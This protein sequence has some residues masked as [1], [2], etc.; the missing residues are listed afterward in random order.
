[1]EIAREK[2]LSLLILAAV[3]LSCAIGL[4]PELS[5]TRIDRNDNVSHYTLIRGMVEAIEQGHNPL[6]FWS[7]E[8][9]FGY[10][11]IRV[12]QPLAH[13][14]VAGLYFALGKTLSLMTVFSWVRY[15]SLVLLPLTF[16]AAARLLNFGYLTAAFAGAISPLLSAPPIY[17]LEWNSYI[18]RGFGLF[19]Q[20]VAV[21]FCLLTIGFGFQAIRRGKHV[22]LAGI[23]LGL[24]ALSE[25]VYGYMG[26][27]TICLLALMPDP[28]VP[29]GIRIKRT[30][31]IGAISVLLSFFQL[32]P[33]LLDRAIMNRSGLEPNWKFDSWG[34]I[35]VLAWLFKGELLDFGRLPVL[36]LLALTG[37]VLIIWQVRKKQRIAVGSRFLICGAVFWTL[38][39]FGRPFW[40]PLTLLFG[41]PPEMPLHRVV[42][43]VQMFLILLAALGLAGLCSEALR[44]WG[45]PAAAMVAVVV[46]SP[47]LLE[48]AQY[49]SESNAGGERNLVSFASEE[50]QLAGVITSLRERGGRTYPGLITS[51]GYY[52]T[53][54]VVPIYQVLTVDGIPSVSYLAHSLALPGDLITDFDEL[55]PSHYRVFNIQSLL[56]PAKYKQ[57]IPK[58]LTPRLEAGDFVVFNAPGN[59]YFDVV[60]VPAMARADKQSFYAINKMW[61]KGDWPD[62]KTHL[63]LDFFGDAPSGLQQM[64][65]DSPLPAISFPPSEPG[66]VVNQSQTGDVYQAEVNVSRPSFVLFKMTW[67]TNWKMLIDG[68]PVKTVM[69]SP[70]FLG[71]PV[72][73]GRHQLWCRYEPGNWKL[74]VAFS[75][76]FCVSLLG[77]AERFGYLP[78]T[79]NERLPA[80][81]EPAPP[82]TLEP[83]P[84]KAAPGRSRKRRTSV[85]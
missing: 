39:F 32:L 42:G 57:S 63:L 81:S 83:A 1:M 75:G 37:A 38:V 25:L 78:S 60:D 51:W 48:R 62:H 46:L 52:L 2:R 59:G 31:V 77:A 20:A 10:P 85:K 67:H 26:A 11:E 19:P 43:A 65:P 3:V 15:L 54:G 22:A 58:M 6:D 29:R 53:V 16:F 28:D 35:Q 55:R 44:R 82:V 70:G 30:V 68:K 73:P 34:P 41:V 64:S 79:R 80:E 72:T 17:G 14:I 47:A 33:P 84:A 8:T 56:A 76:L 61:L 4:W 13:A 21:H 40:G 69:L 23:F 7:P 36:S 24:T 74:L 71:A 12:Y 45:A 66:Q 9:V 27:V 5:I 18:W 50:S 49:I